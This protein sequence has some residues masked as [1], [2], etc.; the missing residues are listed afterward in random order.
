[1]ER[2]VIRGVPM[3]MRALLAKAPPAEVRG[4]YARARL[5]SARIYWRGADVDQAAVLESEWPGVRPDDASLLLG[6]AIALRAGP[7][8]AAEMMRKAPLV[9]GG[10]ADVRAL[11]A[12][13]AKPGFSYAGFAAFDAALIRQVFAPQGAP[14]TYFQDL[15]RRYRDAAG[16]LT[17]ARQ[18]AV[19]V[20]RASAAEQTAVAIR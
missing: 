1:M 9:R 7:E 16:K 20:E 4:L 3:P 6:I 12:L 2:F 14:A 10:E 8:D 11:D 15:A 5:E 19:A 13:A 17:D 18:K